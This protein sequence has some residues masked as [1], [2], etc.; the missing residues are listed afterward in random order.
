ME[1]IMNASLC[2]ENLEQDNISS[3]RNLASNQTA[4]I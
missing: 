3:K 2:T 1:G 4:H